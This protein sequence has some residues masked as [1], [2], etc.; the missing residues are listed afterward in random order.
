MKSNSNPQIIHI[1]YHTCVVD[2]QASM[3]ETAPLILRAIKER[4]MLDGTHG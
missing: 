1:E 4:S 3:L 2:K